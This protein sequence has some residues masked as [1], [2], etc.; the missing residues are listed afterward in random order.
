MKERS[1]PVWH[2]DREPLIPYRAEQVLYDLLGGVP[3]AHV[4]VYE[5]TEVGGELAKNPLKRFLVA[6]AK[7]PQPLALRRPVIVW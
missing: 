5:S 6:G 2:L 3:V 1:H 7:P 4:R